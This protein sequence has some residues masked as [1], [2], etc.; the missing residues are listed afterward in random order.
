MHNQF[1]SIFLPRTGSTTKESYPCLFGY[2]MGLFVLPLR[3]FP[4]I[5]VLKAL[6]VGVFLN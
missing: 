4:F 2:G 6:E 3:H 1:M 5:G